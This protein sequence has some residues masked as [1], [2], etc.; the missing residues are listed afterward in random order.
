MGI[1]I[2]LEQQNCH[3]IVRFL[4]EH[5]CGNIPIRISQSFIFDL[6]YLRAHRCTLTLVRM[7]NKLKLRSNNTSYRKMVDKGF[8]KSP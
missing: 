5:Y 6:H 3:I 4:L 8:S 1:F 2:I 7:K